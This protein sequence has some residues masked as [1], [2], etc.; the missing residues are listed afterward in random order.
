MKSVVIAICLVC[1][2]AVASHAHA[3]TMVKIGIF[4]TKVRTTDC[5]ASIYA[6]RCGAQVG[7][8]MGC[9]SGGGCGPQVAHHGGG[10]CGSGHAHARC[11]TC[12]QNGCVPCGSGGQAPFGVNCVPNYGTHTQN[13]TESFIPYTDPALQMQQLQFQQGAGA[14][15]RYRGY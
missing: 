9:G 14:Q 7:Y 11:A 8:G 6:S 13:C 15:M 2:F 5:G 1:L 4:G 10:G 3:R 12:P